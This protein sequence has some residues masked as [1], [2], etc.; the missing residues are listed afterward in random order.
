M[1]MVNN[2]ALVA[3]AGAYLIAEKVIGRKCA[4][5]GWRGHPQHQGRVATE[6]LA[7]VSVT[8]STMSKTK[9]FYNES[10]SEWNP[11][12]F[13]RVVEQYQLRIYR[14]I[15]AMVGEAE[16]AQDLTQDAFLSAYKNL[17]K[18]AEAA[19]AAEEA[20]FEE[21]LERFHPNNNNLS[22]WLYTIARNTALSEMRRRK[23]VRFFSFWQSTGQNQNGEEIDGMAD[24][25]AVEA[26]GGC[27][28]PRGFKR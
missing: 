19:Q 9:S 18:R 1:Q 21:E 2:K 11:A 15:Y 8:V 7:K 16:T 24:F 3:G 25:A 23:I 28:S 27:G 14:F 26:G 17:L 6:E 10:G 13:D 5:V 20:G 12:T 4:G 22:A